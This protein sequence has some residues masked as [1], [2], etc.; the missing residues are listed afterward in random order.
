MVLKPSW[1]I[2]SAVWS[3]AELDFVTS[4]SVLLLQFLL[5]E[6]YGVVKVDHL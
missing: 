4:S 5:W 3:W 2:L 1:K 6:A